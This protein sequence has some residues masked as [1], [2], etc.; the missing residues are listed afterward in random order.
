M[1]E[2]LR[3]FDTIEVEIEDLALTGKSIGHH[4][5][6]VIMSDQ[7]LPGER[8]SCQIT[9]TKRRYA[10]A[11]FKELLR[12]SPRR[13]EPRCSNF[14]RC[15][16]CTWQ[17]LEYTDQIEFKTRFIREAIARIGKLSNIPIEPPVVA[18]ETFYYRNK[19]EYTFGHHDDDQAV[20]MHVRGRFDKVF[21]LKECY[22][23][24]EQSVQALEVV[25]RAAIDLQIPFM[26]ERTGEGELRFLVVREGKL[27]GD[28]ML[29][30][31]T[32]NR[33]FA[34]RA[35]LFERTIKGVPGLT[36]FFHT[37]NGKK[38]NVA[39]GDELIPIYGKD[40]LTEMIGDLE[41]RITPF[42]FFQTNSSQT[43]ALYDVILDHVA[44]K[45][46]QRLLDLFCGC[47]TI[48]LYLARQVG[49]VLGI[50]LN[51]EAIEMAK[52]NAALNSIENAE[53]IAG[54]VRKLLVELSQSNRHFDTIITDPPRAG[55]EQKAIQ[56]IVRL[57]ADKIVAVSCNP[58][59]L[60]RDLELFAEAGYFT[61]RVTPV[62]MFPQTAHI[63]AVATLLRDP[64]FQPPDAE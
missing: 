15:G 3:K 36:S 54:D 59:T 9:M 28:F 26:N 55:M 64:D 31:V 4:N 62:D 24:S 5:G 50:E 10:I 21:D 42:S 58:A 37:V 51:A 27:T 49:A 17:N 1:I 63:E 61:Q 32:F 11:R 16:G 18:G 41:F 57:Q 45:A 34:G 35:E 6:M 48:A 52:Q 33:E 2:K 39:I 53:F 47:G 56:R 60:A 29:N 25:R 40:H 14:T 44:P 20:G 8:I 7:G 46:D 43:K 30:L 13:I 19:M 22:L 38:A 12:P 23:Q